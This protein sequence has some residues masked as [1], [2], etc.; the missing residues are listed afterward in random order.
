VPIDP[1]KVLV[2]KGLYR[3]VRNPMYIGVGLVLGGDS[4]HFQSLR[5]VAYV[6]LAWLACHLFVIFYEEPTL[7]KKFRTA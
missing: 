1:P 3:F 5:L 7:R 4:I 6:L 2:A